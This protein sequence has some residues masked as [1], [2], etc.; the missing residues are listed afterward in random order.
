[1]SR[2]PRSC[3]EQRLSRRATTMAPGGRLASESPVVRPVGTVSA[4]KPIGCYTVKPS[5]I[6]YYDADHQPV[7]VGGGGQ[8]TLKDGSDST[9]VQVGV[10][11]VAYPYSKT[12]YPA[13]ATF[14]ALALPEGF[15]VSSLSVSIRGRLTQAGN[16][17][18]T[19]DVANGIVPAG[20][21]TPHYTNGAWFNDAGFSALPIN[22]S[23]Q[24]WTDTLDPDN[25]WYS[26]TL[27]SA[28]DI[29]AGVVQIYFAAG[30]NYPE[31]GLR[32]VDVAEV[33]LTVCSA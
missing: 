11:R 18:L 22:E 10:D 15:V 31:E 12:Y 33:S 23:W 30:T 4:G 6:T 2:R 16:V 32:W 29:E 25:I 17:W 13:V 8:N 26:G 24:T 1:M 19:Y 9:Y 7:Y 20:T 28:A 27:P 3:F 5:A 14:E 21:W